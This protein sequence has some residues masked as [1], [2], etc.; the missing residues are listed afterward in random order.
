MDEELS[1]REAKKRSDAIDNELKR[2]SMSRKST[3]NKGP[4]LLLLGSGDSGKTTV[5]KQLKIIHG[6]GFTDVERA[7]YRKH[8]QENIV[9]N[10][11]RLVEALEIF[12]LALANPL[13]QIH[14]RTVEEFRN[15]NNR[16]HGIPASVIL[17]IKS[18][19]ADA[20][21]QQALRRSNELPE[22]QET[23]EFF[24]NDID[25]CASESFV[26]TNDDILHAR[27]RTTEVTETQFVISNLVYK[28]YDVGGQRSMRQ[29]WAPYF[30]GAITA[31][32]FV[33]SIAGY[34]QVLVEDP[35]VNRMY[36]AIALFQSVCNN[37]LLKSVNIIL[38]LNKVD[39]LQ[40]KIQKSTIRRYFPD[41]DGDT[42]VKAAGAFFKAKFVSRNQ[43]TTRKI[44]THFTTGTDTAHMSVIIS[45]VKDI[46]LRMALTSSGIL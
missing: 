33:V 24:L 7:T 21:I 34:D 38:F 5:L 11:C 2:E 46:V 19:W 15:M 14:S 40:K 12:D 25:R 16:G 17:P 27:F 26:P 28:I 45:A 29:F 37:P 8:I 13:N 43:S 32:L 9:T 20:G 23:V 36:D 44:Y 22:Y 10:I 4:K 18:L 1:W 39:L 30:E 31:I 42:S 6:D 3:T 41:F 35:S